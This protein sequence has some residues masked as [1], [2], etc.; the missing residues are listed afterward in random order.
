M[1]I[2]YEKLEKEILAL[3]SKQKAALAITL[4]EELDNSTDENVEE[5]WIEEAE[6]RYQS[7]KAGELEAV[8]GEEA[9]KRVQTRLNR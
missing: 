9:L 8:D 6:R 3:S 1:S 5:L 4:I 2:E 7:Y